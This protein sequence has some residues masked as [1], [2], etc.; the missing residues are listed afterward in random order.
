MSAAAARKLTA[1]QARKD[2]CGIMNTAGHEVRIKRIIDTLGDH[3]F[4]EYLRHM[5]KS[6]GYYYDSDSCYDSDEDSDSDSDSEV[7]HTFRP[8][9][10]HIWDDL[11]D[12]FDGFR[13]ASDLIDA[14]N[15]LGEEE[16]MNCI[17]NNLKEKGFDISRKIVIPA[18]A[19][20]SKTCTITVVAASKPAAAAVEDEDEDEYEVEYEAKAKADAILAKAKA[21]ADA[22]LAEA[23]AKANAMLVEAK[24]MLVEAKA[25][26][27]KAAISA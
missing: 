11:G 8:K 26:L 13:E 10:K 1:A 22:I 21:E 3:D 27:D 18:P 12:I 23:K 2:I 17:R 24:A 19:P 25:M 5:F 16:F 7:R 15:I 6:W 20:P 4:I 9:H 14:A